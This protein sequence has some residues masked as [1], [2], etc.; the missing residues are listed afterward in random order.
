LAVGGGDVDSDTFA[1]PPDSHAQVS[2][3]I[4]NRMQMSDYIH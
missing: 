4:L 2:S 3:G 1:H